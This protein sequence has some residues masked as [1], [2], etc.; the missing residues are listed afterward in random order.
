L[1][2]FIGAVFTKALYQYL[3]KPLKDPH[4]QKQKPKA[5]GDDGKYD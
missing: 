2:L 5:A 1:L 4:R 3:D